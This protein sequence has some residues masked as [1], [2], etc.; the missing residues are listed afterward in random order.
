MLHT[1]RDAS[2]I[3]F[4]AICQPCLDVRSNP[5]TL[6]VWLEVVGTTAG[7]R[8]AALLCDTGARES[9]ATRAV[10][11]EMEIRDMTR[12]FLPER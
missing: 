6:I 5:E 9:A 2:S 7:R 8:G 12:A 10:Q 1:A 4:S 3:R 11:T